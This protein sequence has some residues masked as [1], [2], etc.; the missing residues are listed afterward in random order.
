MDIQ[1]RRYRIGEGKLEEFV[2]GWRAGVVP[3]REQYGFTLL[4][5][6]SIPESNEFM[7]VISYDG[8]GSF[9]DADA[10]YYASDDRH[11]LSPDPAAHIV[12]MDHSMAQSVI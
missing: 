2:D 11:N 1:I 8:P 4:G 12:E 6:W 5:A 7:W 9:A 3:L 10:R